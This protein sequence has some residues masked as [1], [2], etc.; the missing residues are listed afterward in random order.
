MKGVL[1]LRGSKTKFPL[2]GS[3]EILFQ[4]TSL[5]PI[6]TVSYK[7]S[8]FSSKKF[9]NILLILNCDPPVTSPCLSNFFGGLETL[10]ND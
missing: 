5:T 7:T 9:A 6:E 1:D 2:F 3:P 8:S 4:L 10:L